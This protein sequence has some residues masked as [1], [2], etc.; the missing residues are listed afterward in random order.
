MLG[1][2][3]AG[4]PVVGTIRPLIFLAINDSAEIQTLSFLKGLK[5]L[6]HFSFVGTNVKD[7]DLSACIGIDH[8]GFNNKR[9]YS[10]TYDQLKNKD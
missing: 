5:L 10:H 9:H 7:G 6:R 3:G 1:F 8:V 2:A 4:V